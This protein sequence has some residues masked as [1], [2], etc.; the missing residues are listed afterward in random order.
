MKKILFFLLTV[1]LIVSCKNDDTDFSEYINGGSSAKTIYIT[2][3]EGSAT[4]TGDSQG[5]VSVSGADVVVNSQS[6]DSLLLVLSGSTT[7]GSLLVYRSRQFGIQLNGV[8]IT[9]HDGPAINNQ[10][11]KALYIHCASGTTNTLCDGTTYAEQSYDQKGTLFSEGQIYF[12]GTGTLN[13]NA[14]AKNAIASD[15]YIYILGDVVINT[16]TAATGSNGIKVNDGIYIQGGTTT[17]DVSSD[18]GRGIK[19]DSVMI[20]SGGTTTISTSGDC[21]YDEEE[22]DY[23]SAACIKCAY[24]FTMSGG[25]L[26]MKSTGDGGKGLNCAAGV[27]VSGGTFSAITS[28]SNDKAKPKAVKGTAITL[29]GGSFFAMTDKSWACDNGSDS[30]TYSERVTTVGS[31][32]TTTTTTIDGDEYTS[33]YYSKKVIF[34]AF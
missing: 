25:K 9:N 32:S 17:I 16:T 24:D 11:G 3:S 30:E 27:T 12:D 2:Y 10:C 5:I 22:A 19:C 7:D 18:A 31:P 13:V 20:I 23:S 14:K 34:I 29:S 21:V 26:S 1:T 28:G 33:P 15:D 4:V 8:T 6:A